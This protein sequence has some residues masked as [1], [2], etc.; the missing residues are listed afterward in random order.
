[1]IE[2][3]KL[4]LGTLAQTSIYPREVVRIALTHNAA[5]IIFAFVP[6]NK[7]GVMCPGFLCGAIT[8]SGVR[9]MS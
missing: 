3:A 6:V 9:T 1:V 2:Y 8:E 5:A 4:F 7:M